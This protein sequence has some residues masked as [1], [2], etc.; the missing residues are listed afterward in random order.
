MTRR[1]HTH[2]C[3]RALSHTK[4]LKKHCKMNKNPNKYIH[5]NINHVP[6][7]PTQKQTTKK[8]TKTDRETQR[9]SS[10]GKSPIML[11]AWRAVAICFQWCRLL[12]P[13]RGPQR[14]CRRPSDPKTAALEGEGRHERARERER[15][16]EREREGERERER[17]RERGP[18][19][20]P[21]SWRG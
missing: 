6:M 9:E 3:A 13:F 8:A 12:E 18:G 1:T 21:L 7:I 16:R 19:V 15:H 17:G 2:T 20:V 4:T 11:W 10:R 14:E 5:E